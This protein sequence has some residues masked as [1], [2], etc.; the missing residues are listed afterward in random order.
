MS[1]KVSIIV[2]VYNAS[3]TLDRCLCSV[4]DQTY[5]LFEVIL[6]DDGSVDDSPAICDRYAE[7]DSRFRV[8]HKANGGVSSARNA[9]LQVADG[10]FIMFL[11]ADDVLSQDALEVMS[12]K[13]CDLIMGGFRKVVA[14]KI[15]YVRV[16][17]YNKVY[18]GAMQL[19]VFLNDNIGSSDC[20]MLNSSCFKLYRGSLIHENGLKFDESLKYGEDKIFVFNF[21]KYV[22]SARTVDKVVYDYILVEDSLSSDV[23]SDTHIEQI[24]LLLKL[25]IPLLQKLTEIYPDSSRLKELY[26]VDVVSRYVMRILTC[27]A[28]RRT[29]LMTVD[30]ISLLYSYMAEDKELKIS[31]VRFKQIPSLFL[32]RMGSPR[33]TQRFYSLTSSIFR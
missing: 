13:D 23:K 8:I 31:S 3:S 2:P 22:S 27:Y 29:T 17:K 26:H 15:D 18:D 14:G 25:Y 20:F 4:M 33:F 12:L 10:D 21:L 24:F 30:N 6:V 9:G 16:P 5:D 7:E 19:S 11:D 28:T 32:Q 1:V